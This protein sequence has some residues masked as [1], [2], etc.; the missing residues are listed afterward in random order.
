MILHRTD[1]NHLRGISRDAYFSVCGLDHNIMRNF[2]VRDKSSDLLTVSCIPGM[3]YCSGDE[4]KRSFCYHPGRKFT[5][6]VPRPG[7]FP[8]IGQ[9]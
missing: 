6:K 5:P 9:A 8:V 4:K 3:T 2:L 7:L 1:A